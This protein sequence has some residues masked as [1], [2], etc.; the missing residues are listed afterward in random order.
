MKSNVIKL[1]SRIS[2]AGAQTGCLPGAK[3]NTHLHK[4]MMPI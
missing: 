1:N 2:C 4:I 3:L